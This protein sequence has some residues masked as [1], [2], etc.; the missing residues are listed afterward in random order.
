MTTKTKKK[1]KIPMPEP[2][3]ASTIPPESDLEVLITGLNPRAVL[4]RGFG[5]WSDKMRH[6]WLRQHQKRA[7]AAA[8]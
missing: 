3:L 6:M 1:L 2:I 8:L 4:P 5:L 7:R